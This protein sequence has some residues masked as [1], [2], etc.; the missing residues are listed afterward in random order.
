MN[1]HRKAEMEEDAVT[2]TV[3]LPCLM[4]P[5]GRESDS[6]LEALQPNPAARRLSPWLHRGPASATGLK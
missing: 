6:F 5:S 3:G 1:T 4:R 2:H